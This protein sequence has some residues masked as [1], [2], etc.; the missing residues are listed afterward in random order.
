MS[1]FF[2]LLYIK[3]VAHHPGIMEQAVIGMNDEVKGLLPVG[4]VVRSK[5]KYPFIEL[6]LLDM[7][8]HF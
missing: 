2:L 8:F 7:S 3:A 5:S 4:I 1:C 6:Y